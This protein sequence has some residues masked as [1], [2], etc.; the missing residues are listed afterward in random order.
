MSALG[1]ALER[2]SN[3]DSIAALA[4]R[5]LVDDESEVRRD[6]ARLALKANSTVLKKAIDTLAQQAE[7]TDETIFLLDAT[8]WL[9]SEWQRFASFGTSHPEPIVREHYRL[10]EQEREELLLARTYLPKILHS[11]DYLD[12]WCYG[13]AL[14]ELGKE[15]TIEEIYAA[16]PSQVYRRSYLIWLAKELKKQVEKTRNDQTNK[17]YLPPPAASEKRLDVSIEFD[18]QVLGPFNG[19]LTETYS[20]RAHRW[21]WSWSI[22]IENEPELVHTINSLGSDKIVHV[23]VD[24]RKGRVLPSGSIISSGSEPSARLILQGT[25][26]LE[27]A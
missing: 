10:L 14:L 9:D 18:D 3:L 6:A 13:Q 27:K 4:C 7:K 22:F 12:T 25:G 17:H 1:V 2:G 15:E 24:G 16:L 5:F 19:L 20:R 11:E 21:L 23:T 8:F 26:P